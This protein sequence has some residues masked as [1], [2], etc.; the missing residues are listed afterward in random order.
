MAERRNVQI[1]FEIDRASP[2]LDH[3]L[4]DKIG[5]A[6]G[7]LI[8]SAGM[9]IQISGP[10]IARPDIVSLQPALATEIGAF[11]NNVTRS[12]ALHAL[13]LYTI[14]DVLVVG[15]N[16]IAGLPNMGDKSADKL[17]RWV[18]SRCQVPLLRRPTPQFIAAFCRGLNEVPVQAVPHIYYMG[19]RARFITVYDALNET[20]I[21]KNALERAPSQS[22]RNRL[23]EF[24]TAFSEGRRDAAVR[25]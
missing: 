18:A 24:A 16:R 6:I 4:R 8:G 19:K 22:E 5:L 17:E 1:N 20:D 12:G 14:R 23:Q 7:P 3:I 10:D 13:G 15:R 25:D 11:A 2:Y 21:F 9:E